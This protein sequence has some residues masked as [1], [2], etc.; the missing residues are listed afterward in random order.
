MKVSSHFLNVHFSYS[1]YSVNQ[2][3]AGVFGFKNKWWWKSEIATDRPHKRKGY[4]K[5]WGI[6]AVYERFGL[7]PDW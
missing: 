2:I 5:M 6:L 3:N 1:F 7:Q 4:F